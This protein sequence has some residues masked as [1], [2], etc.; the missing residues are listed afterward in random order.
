MTGA[1]LGLT[2]RQRPERRSRPG[3]NLYDKTYNLS[4][5]PCQSFCDVS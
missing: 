2:K 4:E 1:I 5:R 3:A